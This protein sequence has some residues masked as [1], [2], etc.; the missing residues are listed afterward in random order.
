[1]HLALGYTFCCHFSFVVPLAQCEFLLKANPWSEFVAPPLQTSGE[2][3]PK[4]GRKKSHTLLSFKVS[5]PSRELEDEGHHPSL[6]GG[7][8]AGPSGRSASS[9]G[10]SK[11]VFL[12]KVS[13][14]PF[15]SWIAWKWHCDSVACNW[16]WGYVASAIDLRV[17]RIIQIPHTHHKIHPHPC[18]DSQEL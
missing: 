16:G 13:L 4:R 3:S 15:W 6:A 10:M 5:D 7:Q 2:I 1:M 14:R 17:Y 9:S 11:K 12:R 18:R 8:V